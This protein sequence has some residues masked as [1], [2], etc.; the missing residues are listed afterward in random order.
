A[1][2]ARSRVPGSRPRSRTSAGTSSSRRSTPNWPHSLNSTGS[3]VAFAS[4]R[5]WGLGCREARPSVP[6]PASSM[7]GELRCFAVQRHPIFSLIGP[8]RASQ[9]RWRRLRLSR[10]P[11]L[12]AALSPP[13]VRV[14]LPD[15]PTPNPNEVLVS[16]DSPELQRA[17]LER[18]DKE[19]L[20]TIAAALGVK[21]SSRSRKADLVDLILNASGSRSGGSED[22][23]ATKAPAARS[24]PAETPAE[25]T[26]GAPE[27]KKNGSDAT[28]AN[29]AADTSG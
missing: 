11:Q 15:T 4:E 18:K 3:R 8:I 1:V 14:L 17:T 13:V 5:R 20:T 9:R 22:R 21:A 10:C 27:P 23:A 26:D 24:T 29:G 25:A 2:A 19:E 12:L 16:V 28:P 7:A 6:F